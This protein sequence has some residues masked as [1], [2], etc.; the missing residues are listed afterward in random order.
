MV[1]GVVTHMCVA[2]FVCWRYC[3]V[4]KDVGE[5]TGACGMSGNEWGHTHT[6][7]TIMHVHTHTHTHTMLLFSFLTFAKCC[8]LFSR[9]RD[10]VFIFS[11][12]FCPLSYTYAIYVNLKCMS[13]LVTCTAAGGD[14]HMVMS[15]IHEHAPVTLIL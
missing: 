7:H 2:Y 9:M 14:E 10:V 5:E 6:P 12:L 3:G 8:S 15:A 11:Y 1:R 4:E 13:L